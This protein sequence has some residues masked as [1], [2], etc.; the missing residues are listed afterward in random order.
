M[1]KTKGVGGRAAAAAVCVILGAF[2]T[3]GCAEKSCRVPLSES[4]CA[5]TFDG[6]IQQSFFGVCGSAGPCGAFRVWS[7]PAGFVSLT[8]VYDSAGQHLLS[9]ASCS[10]IPICDPDKFCQTGG[11]SIDVN[12]LCDL[13][14]LPMVCPNT[15]DDADAG[16]TTTNH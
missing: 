1:T 9:S 12:Q 7:T 11:Q 5:A 6:Q 15:V 4:G 14:A 10:D 16:G 3:I 2:A 13:S 8:C